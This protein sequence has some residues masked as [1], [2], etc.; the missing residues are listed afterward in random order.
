ML[1]RS[2]SQ[3]IKKRWRSCTC[4]TCRVFWGQHVMKHKTWRGYKWHMGQGPRQSIRGPTVDPAPSFTETDISLPAQ[5]TWTWEL[6][7]IQSISFTHTSMS[8][9]MLCGSRQ[10]DEKSIP[11][12]SIIKG[13]CVPHHTMCGNTRDLSAV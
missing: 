5:G 10:P 9:H 3:R 4:A 8:L 12:R 11:Q 2:Q 7:A 13:E 6:G 1:F